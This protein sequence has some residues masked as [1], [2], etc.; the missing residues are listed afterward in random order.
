MKSEG[1]GWFGIFRLGLVQTALGAIVVL[2]TSTINRVMIVEL[3]LPALV[4]G[5]LVTWHYALQML[6]PRWGHGSDQGGL[7]T[8]WII[9]GMAILA[10]GGIA[11]AISVEVTTHSMIGGLAAAFVAFTLIGIGVGAAGT[12]LL[13]LLAKSVT[14]SRR[15]AA[16]TIVWIMMIAGFIITSATVGHVLDPFTPRR[17]IKVA[18]AVCLVALLV[19]I[20]AV[21]G[22]EG[23]TS[24]PAVAETSN[25]EKTFRVALAHVWSDKAAR[26]FSI[27][28]F[29]SM[30]A[31]SA[32]DLILEPFAALGFGMTPGESTS[33]SG[34]Q[35]TGV[36]LGMIL[37]GLLA[38]ISALST[39]FSLRGWMVAGC[40]ASAISLSGLV[41][42]AFASSNWPLKPNVFLLGFS[43]GVYAVAAIGSMFSM[44]INGRDE[45]DGIRMGVFGAAQAIAFGLGGLAGTLLSDVMRLLTGSPVLAYATVFA[46]EA[47]LF[48]MAAVLAAGIGRAFA[49]KKRVNPLLMAA[50]QQAGGN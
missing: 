43:N 36:L 42:A 44:A 27:F 46:L 4:P 37:V 2:T 1:L 12:S 49:E 39:R 23:R 13:V 15:P 25:S 24:A 16:A 18:V 28:I 32:Q 7:R 6:R 9:A 19:S 11:A 33:L 17:L 3:M 29:V 10:A 34:T 47:G 50:S 8:P 20:I 5:L 30:L 22:V 35:N 40:I 48:L 31:Y 14:P 26:R 41:A 38:S 45:R 21:W